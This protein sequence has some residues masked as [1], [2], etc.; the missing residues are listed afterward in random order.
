ML[1]AWQLHFVM[2]HTRNHGATYQELW[3]IFSE[4]KACMDL[5]LITVVHIFTVVGTYTSQEFQ[6]R[7]RDIRPLM[8]LS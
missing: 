5:L 7:G 3:C 8:N 1:Y 4:S 6:F 2:L